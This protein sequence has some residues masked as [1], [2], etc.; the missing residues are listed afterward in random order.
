MKYL[1]PRSIILAV[2]VAF[3]AGCGGDGNDSK[4]ARRSA[5]VNMREA[6]EKADALIYRTLSS[7]EPPLHWTHDVSD[8]GPCTDSPGLGDVTRRAV[9]MTQVSPQRRA[10]LLGVIERF[11]KK[12]GYKISKVNPSKEFP[13]IYADA[14][15]G[16][17]KM[18]LIVGYKGQFSL[19]VQTACVER[20]EVPHPT[21]R[22][23]GTDYR[24][25]KIPSPNVES[26]FWS[27]DS[28]A[29]S[30]ASTQR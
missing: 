18:S 24:G 10:A 14:D 11:W 2:V 21:T 15:D 3:V 22:A 26:S 12:S 8:D 19:N 4:D 30:A 5:D 13:A 16:V 29:P 7:V 20:S 27:A 1:L 9:V 28:P 6:A 23:K 17:L 25:K